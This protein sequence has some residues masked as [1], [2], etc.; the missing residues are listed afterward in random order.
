MGVSAAIDVIQSEK[1]RFIFSTAPTNTP[2]AL[3]SLMPDLFPI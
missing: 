3:K 1:G 2:I